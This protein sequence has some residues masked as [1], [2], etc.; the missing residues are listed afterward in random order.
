MYSPA[1]T[2][3]NENTFTAPE[4]LNPSLNTHLQHYISCE[5]FNL[6]HW[7]ILDEST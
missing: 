4:G 1:I 7:Q 6:F 3:E 5:R 2:V